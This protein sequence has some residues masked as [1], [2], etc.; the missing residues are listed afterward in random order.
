MKAFVLL[1][2]LLVS[3]AAGAAAPAPPPAASDA[4]RPWAAGV[5]PEEQATAERLF[6][7]ATD[8]L[9]EAFFKRAVDL[10]KEALSHWD[11]PAIHFNL[12]KALMNLD[13]PAAAYTH[14]KASMRF[15]G[16][17]LTADQR[18]QVERYTTLLYETE[19]AE[20][21]IVVEQVGVKVTLDGVD[22]FV[23]PGRW[24]GVVRPETT[25]TLLATQTGFQ[26][27]QIQPELI[28]GQVNLIQ[29]ELLPLELVTRFEREFDT[30]IPWT[31]LGSGLAILGGGAALTWQSGKSFDDYDTGVAACNAASPL[32]VTDD[33]GNTVSGS[34]FI[35]TCLPDKA[36]S[37]KKAQG[38]TFQTLS[39]VAYAVGGT[40]VAAGIVLFIINRERPITT[41]AP[42]PLE[43]GPPVSILPYVGPAQAGFTATFGF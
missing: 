8:L 27:Q 22:L 28:K 33:A 31:V 5:A 19:L 20:L 32:Q 6:A 16:Q 38:E 42:A 34:G 24:K 30:W 11:H 4:D 41:D 15:G 7:E 1:M 13:D 37:D 35:G 9:K 18:E 10:Y 12:A 3:S 26:T 2:C 29:I 39:T 36:L 23:G 17:P 21:E 43:D 14:L 40:A 25:K